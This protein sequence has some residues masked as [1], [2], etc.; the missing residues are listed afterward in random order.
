MSQET[1]K[2]I[3]NRKST[4][5]L[6]K[7]Y[8]GYNRPPISHREWAKEILE[9][10]NFDFNKEKEAAELIKLKREKEDQAFQRRYPV[11]SFLARNRFRIW[12]AL[13]VLNLGMLAIWFLLG[14]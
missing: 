10:R 13:V 5:E 12:L 9:E 11:Y 1:W 3:L 8:R 2:D 4:E 7:I 14:D 6:F